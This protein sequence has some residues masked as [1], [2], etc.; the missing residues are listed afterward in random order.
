MRFVR[1]PTGPGYGRT[2]ARD[3]AAPSRKWSRSA[4]AHSAT[5]SYVSAEPGAVFFQDAAVHD[6]EDSR[7]P[8]LFCGLLVDD[9]FLHPDA[10]GL[11]LDCLIYQFFHEFRAP[12]NVHDV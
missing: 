2:L 8:S 10:W 1:S 3:L 5:Q 9:I 7:S 6:Y 12:E 4:I 11:E